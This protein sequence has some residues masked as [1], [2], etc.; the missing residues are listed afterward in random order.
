MLSQLGPY[1][2]DEELAQGGMARVF[3]ARLRGLGG[4]EKTLVIKQILPELA[5]D[6]RFVE[7]FVREANTLVSLSHPHI[8]PVYELGAA[9]GTYYLSMEYVEGATMA[10]MLEHGPLSPALVAHLGVQIC[11]A[12]DYAHSRFGILHRDLTPRNII[13]DQAGHARLVDFGIAAS[14]DAVD[15]AAFG[16]PG[17]IPPEQLEGQ[18]V[19]AQSD[20]FALGAVLFEALTAKPAFPKTLRGSLD[21]PLPFPVTPTLPEE[22]RSLVQRLLASSASARPRSAAEVA[23]HLRAFSAREHP[24]GALEEMQRRVREAR[25]TRSSPAPVPPPAPADSTARIEAKAIATSPVLTEILRS[26]AFAPIPK[27]PGAQP[28]VPDGAQ[29]SA[30]PL[31]DSTRRIRDSRATPEP[32]EPEATPVDRTNPRL[33]SLMVRA[34]PLLALLALAAAWLGNSEA[35]RRTPA[36]ST[37][38]APK[39]EQGP[40][41]A[42]GTPAARPSAPVEPAPIPALE[43]PT[44]AQEPATSPAGQS[45][46]SVNAKPWAEVLVDGRSVG[47]TPLRKL[48]LRAGVH[49]LN[50]RCPPLGRETSLKL[51]FAPAQSARVMVDLSA[52]PARTFLDGVREAR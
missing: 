21:P 29:P 19:T 42:G 50:L 26:S 17:Y 5:K 10:Q 45:L 38:G 7:L 14:A 20:L 35:L 3:R 34:W 6:P 32:A 39:L 2:I 30:A 44:K 43:P 25:P 31:A 12:L 40:A 11:E 46:V 28:R 9:E 37:P 18:R 16:S 49:T 4:F 24:H 33:T 51:D 22:L 36:A 52:T 13:V 8:V 1:L 41:D 48:K 23:R 15:S 27:P 47:T